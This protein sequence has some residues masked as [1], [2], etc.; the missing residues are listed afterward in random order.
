MNPT[1]ILN[2]STGFAAAGF[3]KTVLLNQTGYLL[4]LAAFQTEKDDVP[5]QS[6]GVAAA[7]G[8]NGLPQRVK[9]DAGELVKGMAASYILTVRHIG[10]PDPDTGKKPEFLRDIKGK[11]GTPLLKEPLHVVQAGVNFGLVAKEAHERAQAKMFGTDPTDRI[12]AIRKEAEEQAKIITKPLQAAFE[13]YIRA[14]VNAPDDEL[15]DTAMEALVNAKR[16]P[17][18]EMKQ[19]A[20]AY[21]KAMAERHKAGKWTNV[22]AGIWAMAQG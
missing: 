9:L 8:D 10:T 15:I 16:D 21:V 1:A 18:A 14:N 11:D 19:A 13:V 20:K 22:D 6:A 7:F 12:A 5:V 3:A 17:A 2:G 4:R